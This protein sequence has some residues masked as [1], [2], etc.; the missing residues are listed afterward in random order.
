[1]TIVSKMYIYILYIELSVPL[2]NRIATI[3][4]YHSNAILLGFFSF[5]GKENRLFYKIWWRN[6]HCWWSSVGRIK[7]QF[8]SN[9]PSNEEITK[10]F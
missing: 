1:M 7:R 8:V 6:H 3:I 2:I 9:V 4:K 10:D 5:G